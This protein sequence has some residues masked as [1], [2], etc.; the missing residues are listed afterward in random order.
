M[1]CPSP[2][3]RTQRRAPI[4]RLPPVTT[5]MGCW[6]TSVL[7]CS[8]MAGDQRSSYAPPASRER[9]A[10][11]VRCCDA[12]S[13][14]TRRKRAG[15]PRGRAQAGRRGLAEA[16]CPADLAAAGVRFVRSDRYAPGD[17]AGLLAGGSD[18]VVDCIGYTA[19]HARMLLPFGPGIGSLVFI[20]SKAVYVDDLGRHSN[21]DDPPDF[22][23]AVTEE[24]PTMKPSDVDYNSREG[25]G[26]NKVAA[27]HVLLDSGMLVSVLRPSRV[28]G[29]G[30]AR[31]RE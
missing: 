22:G 3:G 5:V 16:R 26:A 2:A 31:P 15:G 28:H 9:A 10:P 20:S 19:E 1:S 27:E 17:L 8:G 23:G 11:A 18:V 14:G 21:T 4:P 6:G 30:S 12:E 7:C 29:V 24:Q 25:Y 13:G